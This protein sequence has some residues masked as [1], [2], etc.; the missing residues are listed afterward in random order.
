MTIF[1]NVITIFVYFMTFFIPAMNTFDS[2]TYDL[3]F[4][5]KSKIII[6]GGSL[7]GKTYVAYFRIHTF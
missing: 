5:R 7:S 4:V 6:L 1:L 2:K 3:E